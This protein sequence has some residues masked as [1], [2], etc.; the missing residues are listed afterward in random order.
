MSDATSPLASL[1]TRMQHG[2]KWNIVSAVFTQG[3]VFFA[4]IIIANMLGRHVYGEFGMIQ[5]TLLT[6]T[7]IAQVATGM[8][9]TKYVAEF[10]STDKEKAGRILGLCSVVTLITAG[11]AT[12][13]LLF[14][15]QWLA[16]TTLK[17]PH[18]AHGLMI[19][20]GFVM[21]SVI[22]GYQAGALAGLEGYRAL[23]RVGTIQGVV[24]LVVCTLSAWYFGLEGVLWGVVVS[25]FFRWYVFKRALHNESRK[26]SIAITYTHFWQEREIIYGFAVPAAISGLTSMPALWAANAFLVQQQDGYSQMGLYSAANILRTLVL[27]LPILANNVGMSLLNNQKGSGDNSKYKKVF[28]TNL[29]VTVASV[30]VGALFVSLSGPLLLRLFGKGFSEGLPVLLVLMV[31][32]I[33][34]SISVAVFQIMQCHEMMW[35]S[36][37]AVS[38]PRDLMIA[39]LSYYLT[40]TY[41]AVGLA[42]A[43]TMSWTFALFIIL[44]VVNKQGVEIKTVC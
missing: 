18:L 43:Y 41:G 22:N 1:R 35:R 11:V 10:R 4:N 27:F 19:T 21:F 15:A 29:C 8:T 39:C 23:A 6:M 9:A 12:L 3:S 40:P 30:L 14:G 5:S 7:G 28:W 25:A 13:L 20:S 2:I 16:T 26:H 38:L 17:A 24:H 33:P 37:F 32:T 31:S 34:E 42:W 44:L 36:L